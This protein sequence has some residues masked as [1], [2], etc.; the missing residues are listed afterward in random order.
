MDQDHVWQARTSAV[1]LLQGRTS[2]QRRPYRCGTA[3]VLIVKIHD[4][5]LKIHEKR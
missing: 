1:T 3:V 5:S 2:T 4:F